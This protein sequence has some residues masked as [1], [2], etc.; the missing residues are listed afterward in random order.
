MRIASCTKTLSLL[1]LA[2]GLAA[3]GG[4][5]A[6]DGHSSSSATA[7]S[8]STVVTATSSNKLITFDRTSPTTA[9][10]SLNIAGLAAGEFIIGMDQNSSDNQFYALT[11]KGA[12]VLLNIISGVATPLQ[13]FEPSMPTLTSLASGG[14]LQGFNFNPATGLLQVI[15]GNGDNA[16]I[17]LKGKLV[18]TGTGFKGSLTGAGFSDAVNGGAT[19]TLSAIDGATGKLFLNLDP[20]GGALGSGTPLSLG[21]I[22]GTAGY[23][24]SATEQ[25]GYAL[26]DINNVWKVVQLN[27]SGKSV[28]SPATILGNVPGLGSGDTPSAMALVQPVVQ[29]LGLVGGNQLESFL[30]QDPSTILSTL[31]ISGLG[32]GEQML[33]IATNPLTNLLYGLANDGKLFLINPQTGA[34]SFVSQLSQ[35]LQGNSFTMAFNPVTNALQII[36]DQG[37]NL[38]LSPDGATSLLTSIL[39]LVGNLLGTLLGHDPAICGA[40]FTNNY[41]G[42]ALTDLLSI[43]KVNAALLQLPSGGTQMLDL[44]SLG[45]NNIGCSG[46]TILGGN[47]GLSLAALQSTLTNGPS[48]LYSIAQGSGL[49]TLIGPI[50]GANGLPLTSLTSLLTN[51]LNM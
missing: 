11:N 15:G 48:Q 43:D 18:T 19:T 22:T 14:P 16:L 51:P 39:N 20:N 25:K 50:G 37:Q 40:S 47:N 42:A 1:A 10:T 31:P 28:G 44:G 9:K 27:L 32:N 49:A 35:P 21:S 23:D 6:T 38:Q 33:A 24:V 41:S 5:V 12:I 26:L 36:S 46:L 13:G 3:C 8:P 34:A 2:V 7:G 45:L 29:M 4:G 17:N 30:P